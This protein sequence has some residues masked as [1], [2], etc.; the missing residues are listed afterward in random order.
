MATVESANDQT[1]DLGHSGQDDDQQEFD[2][3]SEPVCECCSITRTEPYQPQSAQVKKKKQSQ[4]FQAS[5]CH[6]HGWITYCIER[7]K[8]FCFDCRLAATK[9]LISPGNKASKGYAAFVVTGF[10]NRKKAKWRFKEHELS[11]LHTE[12]TV[13][14]K[15]LQQPSVASQL[16]KQ[17]TSDQVK[18]REM[19]LKL[20][21]SIKYLVRQG[22]ALR[23]HVENESNLIQ[24]LKCRSED[25]EGMDKWLEDKK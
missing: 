14:I 24:L 17:L 15:L 9:L 20:L 18:R 16:S 23:G 8:L 4:S 11:Q 2:S 22:L 10:D 12:S 21:S 7:Q 19:L 3:S 1:P 6:D 25:I 13:K 5:W